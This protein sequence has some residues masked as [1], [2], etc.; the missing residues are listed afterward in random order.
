MST[1]IIVLIVVA[2]LIVALALWAVGVYNG[3]VRRRNASTEALRGIDVALETRYDQVSQQAQVV[4]GA[5]GKEVETVLG[6]TALRTGRSIR[7]MSVKEKSELHAA[8]DDAQRRIVE[9]PGALA[10]FEAYPQMRSLANVEVLQRTVNETE[11]R[12]QA[13]RRA[14]NAAATDYNTA[15]QSFPTVLIAGVLGFGHHDLFELTNA[16]KREQAD[17]G[18]FLGGGTPADGTSAAGSRA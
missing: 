5:V 3:L 13:A 10:S 15:R 17:L 16:V 9:A 1:G 4:E 11:E 2:A 14:Y 8:L 6:A 7:E 12:L 18:G